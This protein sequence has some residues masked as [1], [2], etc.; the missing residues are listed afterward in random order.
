[1]K[2]ISIFFKAA[3]RNKRRLRRLVL[4]HHEGVRFTAW[5]IFGIYLKFNKNC[6]WIVQNRQTIIKIF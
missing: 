2:F 4:W 6:N 3:T 1:M 5:N